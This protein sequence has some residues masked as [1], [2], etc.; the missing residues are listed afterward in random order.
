MFQARCFWRVADVPAQRVI[1][2]CVCWRAN[3]GVQASVNPRAETVE[4]LQSRRK[5]L[6]VGMC[7]LLREDLALKAEQL[8][9]DRSQAA[10]AGKIRDRVS[11]EF[12]VGGIRD[13]VVME[14]DELTRAHE[15]VDA[16]AFNSDDAEYKRLM[17][18]AID[19]KALALLKLGVFLESAARGS[20]RAALDRIRD[21]PLAYFA[22]PAVVLPLQT[23]VTQFPWAAV[24][25][26]KSPEIDLGDWDAAP[27]AAQALTSVST[28]LV[29]NTN[30]RVV[31]IKGGK[32]PLIEGWVTT[33]LEWVE[34]KA[35][36][37]AMKA[38]PATVA[39][40]LRNCVALTLLDLR[41][42]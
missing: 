24:V 23:G 11:T 6:H 36:Q 28:A 38:L 42:E 14:F 25:R 20:D 18:E 22:D 37:T 40:V 3:L 8:L 4:E 10:G 1:A 17:A 41:Y 26:D 19:G 35:F 31:I 9:A 13:L 21:A 12:E 7:K 15:R 32:L 27:V 16:D 39:L 5:N 33:R 30:I 34:T 2:G 29:R